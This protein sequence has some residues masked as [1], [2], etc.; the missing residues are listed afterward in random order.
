MA[1][2]G[3]SAVAVV[4]DPNLGCL[5]YLDT[6]DRC[7]T[8]RHVE[9][10]YGSGGWRG[11]D[12]HREVAVQA[13]HRAPH[14]QAL[15]G[16][17]APARADRSLAAARTG[18]GG[19][20]GAWGSGQR[21][22]GRAQHAMAAAWYGLSMAWPLRG[23]ALLAVAARCLPHDA[24]CGRT[25]CRARPAAAAR[26]RW[27]CPSQVALGG[28]AVRGYELAA[29]TWEQAFLMCPASPDEGQ[30]APLRPDMLI[31]GIFGLSLSGLRRGT[32]R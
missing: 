29:I 12:C 14:W 5:R 13:A 26:L 17:A 28:L 4:G 19:S 21:S 27:P 18:L 3:S 20:R 22:A 16:T 15:P 32:L 8:N 10:L 2:T 23:R 9:C 25:A 30:G 6:S 7:D 24:C 11:V 1:D 31:E